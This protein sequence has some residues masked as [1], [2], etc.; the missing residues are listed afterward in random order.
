MK[1]IAANVFQEISTYFIIVI[2]SG[3]L[4]FFTST[5]FSCII[6]TYGEQE[7]ICST[8]HKEASLLP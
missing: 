2:T 6:H 1:M 4:Y 7:N 5:I 8:F 3:F